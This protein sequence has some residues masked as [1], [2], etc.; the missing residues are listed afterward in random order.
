MISHDP[1]VPQQAVGYILLTLH[2]ALQ[3]TF[4]WVQKKQQKYFDPK[5]IKSES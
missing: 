3:C 4:V 2:E 1:C 5:E